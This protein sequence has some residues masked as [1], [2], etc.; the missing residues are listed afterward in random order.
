[1]KTKRRDEAV[2]SKDYARQY[3]EL[4]PELLPEL[5]RVLSSEEPILGESVGRFEEAFARFCGVRH[6]IG[7]NSGTDALWL[8]LRALAIGPGDEV[9]TAANAFVAAATAI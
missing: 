7:V 1:M 4:L 6:A 5:E 3:R 2:P 9:I 8:S